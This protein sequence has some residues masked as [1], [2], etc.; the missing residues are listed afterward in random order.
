MSSKH[1]KFKKVFRS[2]RKCTEPVEVK[3]ARREMFLQ[4][5]PQSPENDTACKQAPIIKTVKT[6]DINTSGVSLQNCF[7][8]FTSKIQ[9]MEERLRRYPSKIFITLKVR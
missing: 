1:L 5:F 4:C 6:D 2:K 8:R 3:T 9:A 7:Q